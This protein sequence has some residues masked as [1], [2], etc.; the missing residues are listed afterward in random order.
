[1]FVLE[2]LAELAPD[3]EVPGKGMVAVL[4]AGIHSSA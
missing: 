3:A 2:P 4:L 1:V